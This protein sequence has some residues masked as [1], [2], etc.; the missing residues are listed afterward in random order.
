MALRGSYLLLTSLL[1]SCVMCCC[2]SGRGKEGSA[3]SGRAAAG[4]EAPMLPDT[5]IIGTLYS[6]T[7]YFIYR[8]EPMGYEYELISKFAADHKLPVKVELADN[9]HDLLRLLHAGK[10]NVLAYEI[11]RTA[12]YKSQVR[13]CG[14]LTET[15]Q[16]LVQ[17]KENGRPLITD[18]T[19]LP[20][21][22]VFVEK[23][24]KY[25]YRLQN[26]N[27]ELGGGILIMPIA[28]DSVMTEDM[29]EMVE[30]GDIPLTVI[31]SDI[32]RIS[33]T[34]YD[35]ID[36]SLPIGME[37]TASWAVAPSDTILAKAIDDWARNGITA[38]ESKEIYRRYYELSKQLP[39]EGD[40][41]VV[42]GAQSAMIGGGRISRYDDIFRRYAKEIGWD[43]R[44]LA[45]Q[46]YNE[47]H[48]DVNVVS[49]AG[50]RG[51]MQLMPR[52]AQAM[53]LP[54]GQITD[55]DLN[56]KAA[57]KAIAALDKM[58]KEKVPDPN[59]RLKFIVAAYNSGGA[60]ILDAIVIARKSGHNPQIWSGEVEKALLL[61]SN[62]QYY[63]DPEVKYGYFKG[64]QTVEYVK[65]VMDTYAMYKAK[66]P[67]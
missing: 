22:R 25:F 64:T 13:H 24:S 17:H 39:A 56:V 54:A 58:F 32:A 52:T 60:H 27:R 63:R 61:K 55:P 6:P 31:D 16:V 11:P 36:V 34:Y 49:W 5:L 30:R 53:G 20:G 21:K 2:G 48:F 62:P 29:I 47:S 45:A 26:L 28:K 3:D 41:G 14:P 18:V 37:Q 8:D 46:A 66:I 15:H 51:L 50:A 12:E 10:V 9:F 67:A 40:N 23:D 44:L 57:V 33:S 38:S 4:S 35:N 19:Q 7:S 65:R 42:A 59:E 1:L 43:W